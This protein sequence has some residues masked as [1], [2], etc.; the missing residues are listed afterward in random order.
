M[1][2]TFLLSVDVELAWGLV[3]FIKINE[4]YLKAFE[5][6]RE[7][8]DP[9][10][11]LISDY[12][13]PVTWFIL[14]HVFLDHCK[15]EGRPH[16]DMPR[17][18]YSWFEGDWYKYDPCSDIYSAPHWYGKDIVEKILNFAKENPMEQEIG[19]HSFS[20]QMFG[21]PGCSTKLARKE[22]DKCLELMRDEG[23][24]PKTFAFPR[25]SVGHINI[26]REK[27]FLAFCSGIPQLVEPTSL[28]RSALNAFRK[29]VSLGI[30]FSSHYFLSPPPVVVPKQA[31]PGLWEV[32]NSMCFNKKRNIPISL[33]VLKAKKGIKRAIKEGKCFHMF[34]HL[35][36][37]GADPATLL[38]TFEN[39]LSVAD[40]ERRRDSLQ[41]VNVESL[42]RMLENQIYG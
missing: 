42:I 8:L 11:Q 36:N 6:V 35:H 29:H 17:P 10:L 4:Q 22:I 41:F 39:V 40:E 16:S 20:H 7:I 23:V 30:E 33:V 24:R 14:G 13:V 25:G 32:P 26:L 19:C 1:R 38:R 37:F 2:G 27:E 28:D 18:D 5:R 15:C 34:T 21:D 31:L 9:L 12:E 3:G